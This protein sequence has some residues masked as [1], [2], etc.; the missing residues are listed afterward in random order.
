[1]PGNTEKLQKLFFIVNF[2]MDDSYPTR[3]ILTLPTTSYVW[4]ISW[5]AKKVA[6]VFK[7]MEELQSF[8]SPE[9]SSSD[10]SMQMWG[11]REKDSNSF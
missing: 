5:R 2:S 6:A 4:S 10:V 3:Y 9:D 8:S 11:I 7:S 1:V